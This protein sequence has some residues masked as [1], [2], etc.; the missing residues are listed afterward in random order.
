VFRLQHSYGK[1]IAGITSGK[2]PRNLSAP[3]IAAAQ[4]SS[5]EGFC[6]SEELLNPPGFSIFEEHKIA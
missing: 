2:K 6:R 3:A 4:S 1:E 5:Q